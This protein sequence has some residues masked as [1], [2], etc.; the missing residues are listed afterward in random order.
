MHSS[1]SGSR[2]SFSAE[3]RA[4]AMIHSMITGSASWMITP[5][6]TPPG[7]AER[8]RPV[9]GDVH[10]DLRLLQRPGELEL[11]VVP[12]DL[13]SVHEPLDHPAG[14][15]EL[16]HLHRLLPDHAARGVAAADPHH[17]SAARDDVQRRVRARE[18]R[19]LARARVR[20]EVTELHASRC[21]RR[22][23]PAAGSTPATG[24]ASRTSTRTRSPAARPEPSS[25]RKRLYGGSGKDGDTER[26]GHGG[27]ERLPR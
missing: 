19:R 14:L 7:D 4:V 17:H 11:L 9:A 22:R 15:L 12:V 27:E 1:T 6:E 3:A 5:S 26:D 16:G 24:C 20:D 13:L 25:S 2:P 18:H 10:R 21:G 23:A 8:L